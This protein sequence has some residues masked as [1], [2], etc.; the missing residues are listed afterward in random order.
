MAVVKKRP[1]LADGTVVEKFESGA[2]LIDI[3]SMSVPRPSWTWTCPKG[4][5]V[6]YERDADYTGPSG[7]HV[8]GTK[9]IPVPA[10]L[11][12]PEYGPETYTVCAVCPRGRKRVDFSGSMM[13]NSTREFMHGMSWYRLNGE[14]V[15]KE[16]ADEVI[17]A[18]Q[19]SRGG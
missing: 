1:V 11:Y 17:A 4:H 14:S 15:T 6:R 18:F 16:R 7:Y 8:V 13:S 3:T 2:D 10:Y 19:K 12:D 9:E 5:I